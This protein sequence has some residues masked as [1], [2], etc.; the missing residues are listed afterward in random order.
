MI[1]LSKREKKLLLLR[2]KYGKKVI[3]GECYRCGLTA[4]RKVHY[5]YPPYWNYVCRKCGK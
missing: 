2:K 1:E 5:E 3:V 4:L